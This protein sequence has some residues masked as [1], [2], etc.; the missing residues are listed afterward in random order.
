[1]QTLAVSETT[2]SVW[3]S[4][5]MEMHRNP[6]RIKAS[7]EMYAWYS[8]TGALSRVL[9]L[10]SVTGQGISHFVDSRNICRSSCKVHFIVFK[11]CKK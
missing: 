4:K 6:Q 2:I 7:Q 5:E 8:N 11:L 3:N 10:S 9:A 1:M